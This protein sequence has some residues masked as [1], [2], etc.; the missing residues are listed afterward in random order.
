MHRQLMRIAVVRTLRT[1]HFVATPVT[2]AIEG[3]PVETVGR[4]TCRV[5]AT[6][7][8]KGRSAYGREHE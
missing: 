6:A 4:A 3:T 5:F 2:D 7:D 8:L 1:H